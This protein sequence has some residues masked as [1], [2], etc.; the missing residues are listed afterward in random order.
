[1]CCGQ[2]FQDEDEKLYGVAAI[3]QYSDSDGSSTDD[4]R[5][6]YFAGDPLFGKT[7]T[8]A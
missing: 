6:E 7:V 4:E 5:L 3:D 8:L 1:M 2:S